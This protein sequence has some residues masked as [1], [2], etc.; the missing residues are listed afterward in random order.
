MKKTTC[1]FLLAVLILLLCACGNGDPATGP[2]WPDEFQGDWYLSV[3][4]ERSSFVTL[5]D[6]DG[7]YHFNLYEKDVVLSE[8][9]LISASEVQIKKYHVLCITPSVTFYHLYDDEGMYGLLMFKKS[10]TEG[11][12]YVISDV[13]EYFVDDGQMTPIGSGSKKSFKTSTEKF[14]LLQPNG[15]YEAGKAISLSADA[16]LVTF[17]VKNLTDGAVADF[18]NLVYFFFRAS[19]IE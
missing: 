7:S 13:S 17:D 5:I 18:G 16:F 4:P 10:E 1:V 8:D 9:G 19:A 6:T 14:F 3:F 12:G 2:A 15:S 11:F